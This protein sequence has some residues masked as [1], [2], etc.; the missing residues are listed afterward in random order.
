MGYYNIVNDYIKLF[1][2]VCE[3]LSHGLRCHDIWIVEIFFRILYF[4]PF[5]SLYCL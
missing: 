2:I 3:K 1:I 4:K 5:F